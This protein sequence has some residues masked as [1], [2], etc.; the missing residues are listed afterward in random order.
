MNVTVQGTTL[1]V[2]SSL[3]SVTYG[4]STSLSGTL[5]T[6]SGAVLSGSSVKILGRQI[7]AA[8]FTTVGT[9]TTDESG[10]YVLSVKPSKGA[11]YYASY[12]GGTGMMGRSTSS[13]L[14][15]VKPK[16][17]LALNDSTATRTQTVYFSGTVSPNAKYQTVYLQRYVSGKWLSAKSMKLTSTSTFKFA[18]KPTSS[19]DYSFRV[20]VPA[21]T[22][23]LAG[24][25]VNK[26][27]T[28][29]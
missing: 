25:T 13:V 20:Y 16:V 18:W 9:A 28:I 15:S 5:K 24:Y 8:S 3:S 4:S 19:A 17:S 1:T 27:L 6:V 2:K 12:A 22:G 11:Y 21:L 26:K 7:G 29:A 10:V 23:Y 14:V